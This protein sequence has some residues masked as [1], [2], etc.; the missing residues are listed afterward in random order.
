MGLEAWMEPQDSL[1]SEHEQ[2]P[3]V[4]CATEPGHCSPASHRLLPHLD[5]PRPGPES[6]ARSLRAP[7]QTSLPRTL[8]ES[9]TGPRHRAGLLFFLP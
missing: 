3:G 2:G 4:P 9:H 7:T 6:R 1:T 5:V 8:E